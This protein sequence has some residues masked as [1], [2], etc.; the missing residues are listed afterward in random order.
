MN[1][2]AKIFL[3]GCCVLALP[4]AALAD[5]ITLSATLDGANE[6]AGGHADGSGMFSAEIDT[7]SGDV[8]YVLAVEG[9]GD[10]VA[11]HIHDGAAGKDGKPVV[12]IDVTGEDEDRCIAVEPDTLKPIVAAPANFYVNVHTAQYPKGAVRGQLETVTED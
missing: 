2:S 9:I 10:A 12:T 1:T 7:E 6:T 3:A 5:T 11:A 8:C 4:A